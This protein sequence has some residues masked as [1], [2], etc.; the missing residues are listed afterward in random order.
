MPAQ[1]QPNSPLSALRNSELRH[2]QKAI[3]KDLR[4]AIADYTAI[5]D[6]IYYKDRLFVPPDPGAPYPN[7]LSDTHS[8]ASAGHPGRFR[9]ID[10]I[11]RTILVASNNKRH[12]DIR[13]GLQ[14]LYPVRNRP[15]SAAAGFLQPLPVPFKPRPDISVDYLDPST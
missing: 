10:L 4:I 3:R 12:R 9:T 13:T 2:R 11:N 14:P 1:T 8:S 15:R 7:P 5:A 6:R